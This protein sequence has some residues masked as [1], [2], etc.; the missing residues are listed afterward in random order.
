MEIGRDCALRIFDFIAASARSLR[1]FARQLKR[2][3]ITVILTPL[4]SDFE[5]EQ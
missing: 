4:T 2:L 5:S 3:Y 1:R